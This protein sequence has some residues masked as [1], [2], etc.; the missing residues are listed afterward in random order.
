M[1]FR[2]SCLILIMLILSSDILVFA[3]KKFNPGF[4]CRDSRKI[5]ISRGTRKIEGLK[6]TRDC[7]EYVYNKICKIPSENNCS[8]Y[9]HCYFVRDPNCLL[10]DSYNNC[11]NLRREYSCKSRKVIRKQNQYVKNSFEQQSGR[12]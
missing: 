8:Q 4:L 12:E 6:V 10:R 7:W 11:V 1:S 2:V 9:A 5:C 3:D